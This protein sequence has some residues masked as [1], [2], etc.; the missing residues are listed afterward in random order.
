MSYLLS[1]QLSTDAAHFLTGTRTLEHITPTS[2]HWL[3][4]R[5]RIDLNLFIAVFGVLRFFEPSFEVDGG[6]AEQWLALSPLR[7]KVLD[8]NLGQ[9]ISLW[10][11]SPCVCVGSF[12]VLLLPPTFQKHAKL[13]VTLIGHSELPVGVNVSVG[14]SAVR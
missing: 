7:K 11:L 6:P 5:F 1:Y 14:T 4:V 3:P 2:L 10:S 13:W 12:R 9:D 8:L